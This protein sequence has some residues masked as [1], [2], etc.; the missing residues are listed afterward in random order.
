MNIINKKEIAMNEAEEKAAKQKADQK[1]GPIDPETGLPKP[2]DP[3]SE[4]EQHRAGVGDDTPAK[5]TH[6]H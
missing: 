3:S 6:S 4:D 1:S 5:T 2:P